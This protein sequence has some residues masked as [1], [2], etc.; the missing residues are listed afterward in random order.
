MVRIESDRLH[1]DK[2]FYVFFRARSILKNK[3]ER[4]WTPVLCP[5]RGA[6]ISKHGQE[7]TQHEC[8]RINQKETAKTLVNSLVGW[9]SFLSLSRDSLVG[10]SRSFF[11]ESLRC[12][13][14]QIGYTEMKW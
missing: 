11:L 10:W 4:R 6:V 5:H 13:D 2:L 12:K 7:L 14:G 9:W 1:V 3:T 8:L